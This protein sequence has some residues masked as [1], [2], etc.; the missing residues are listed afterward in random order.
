MGAM[1]ARSRWIKC[2]S[3]HGNLRGVALQASDVVRDL[4]DR[5]GLKGMGSRGLGEAAVAALLVASSCRQGERVNLN[6]QGSGFFQQGLVD[7]YPEGIVRGYVVER[8]GAHSE[9]FLRIAGDLGP[10]GTGILSV[11]RTRLE[12]ANRPYIGT[13][14]LVTGHLAKDMTFYWVQSEQI[15]SSVGIAINLDEDGRI[16][17]AGGF[18]IQ[19]LPGAS[20]AEVKE[21]EVHIQ[22]IQS[23]AERIAHEENPIHLLSQIFQSTAFMVVDERPLRFEC[24]CSWTR[25]ER[26]L[27]LL[28]GSDLRAIIRDDGKASVRCDF[29]ASEYLVEAAMIEKMIF[30][31]ER[32]G[33]S[34]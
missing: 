5:H 4:T 9:E 6:I 12:E 14:P 24:N 28:S 8:P 7:A 22:E 15:P 16:S 25:V 18:L 11:L 34:T 20:I 21:V 17:S 3:T 10:W 31:R 13:V 2:I 29:C 23:L 1:S 19:A 32:P 33:H 26:A 27:T 30:D